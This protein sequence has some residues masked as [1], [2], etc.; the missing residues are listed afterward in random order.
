[1]DEVYEHVVFDGVAHQSVARRADLAERSVV[2]SSVEALQDPAAWMGLADFYQH[3]RDV[4]AKAL[5]AFYGDGT[6]HGIIRLSFSKDEDT[7]REGARRLC[8]V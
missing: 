2:V 3:K 7:L 8:A 6:D 4:L 1:S 5:S